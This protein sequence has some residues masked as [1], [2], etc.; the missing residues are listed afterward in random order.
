MM[1]TLRR[2]LI[3]SAISVAAASFASASPI[4]GCAA[5]GAFT[6]TAGTQSVCFQGSAADAGISW[7]PNGLNISQFDPT[8]PIYGAFGA[9]LN[10]VEIIGWASGNAQS[11]VFNSSTTTAESYTGSTGTVFL[12]VNGPGGLT[13]NLS[14]SATTPGTTIGAP[15]EVSSALVP[16]STDNTAGGGIFITS[17]FPLF[18][19]LN[20]YIGA[21]TIGSLTAQGAGNTGGTGGGNDISYNVVG[22]VGGTIAVLYDYSPNPSGTPEPA[23]M[24]LM[25]GAL[26]G[27]GMLGKRLKKN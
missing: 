1:T 4:T 15:G 20:P 2:I 21:G 12:T 16:F 18:N 27:L 22:D 5:T 26:I 3:G 8:N 7:G 25:G 24:A 6:V 23:T 10:Y 11:N 13:F 9:T 19:Q 17:S 14:G